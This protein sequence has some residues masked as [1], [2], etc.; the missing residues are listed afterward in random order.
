[1]WDNYLH[2]YIITFHLKCRNYLKKIYC[3]SLK[4]SGVFIGRSLKENTRL[5][6]EAYNVI[7]VAKVGVP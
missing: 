7:P 2:T 5:P 4:N 1:M 3:E 6:T